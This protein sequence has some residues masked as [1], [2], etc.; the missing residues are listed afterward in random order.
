MVEPFNWPSQFSH[1]WCIKHNNG[2]SSRWTRVTW[3]SWQTYSLVIL[4]YVVGIPNNILSWTSGVEVFH[5]RSGLFVHVW[6]G[7]NQLHCWMEQLFC[8]C[9]WLLHLQLHIWGWLFNASNLLFDWVF[10][11]LDIFELGMLVSCLVPSW[12]T[13]GGTK[14]LNQTNCKVSFMFVK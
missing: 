4:F 8:S 7:M 12:G 2:L 5:Y 14:K 6:Q 10:E 9:K 11:G 13:Q 3:S 1:P